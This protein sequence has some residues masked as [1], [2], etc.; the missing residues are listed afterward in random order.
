MDVILHRQD[1]PDCEQTWESLNVFLYLISNTNGLFHWRA[2][3]LKVETM[4]CFPLYPR[5]W[6]RLKVPY[7]SVR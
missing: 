3:R 7:V 6:Y 2:G 1:A 5:V 4:L